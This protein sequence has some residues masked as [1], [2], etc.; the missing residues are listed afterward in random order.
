MNSQCAIHPATAHNRKLQPT[1]SLTNERKRPKT[2]HQ[3]IN[4]YEVWV[5]KR[6][7]GGDQ[8]GEV[9]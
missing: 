1:D 8:R 6:E 9:W 5:R 2:L 4:T 7:G 3:V